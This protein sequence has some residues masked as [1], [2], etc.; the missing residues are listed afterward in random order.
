[1]PSV[2]PWEVLALAATALAAALALP[3]RALTYAVGGCCCQCAPP[4]T[5]CGATCV[6]TV[7]FAVISGSGC[8]GSCTL[9]WLAGVWLGSM[10]L[11]GGNCAGTLGVKLYCD[12]GSWKIDL[13]GCATGTGI[14]LTGTCAPFNIT[15][16]VF[17]FSGT[18]CYTGTPVNVTLTV[19]A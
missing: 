16:G 3:W 7:G 1:M 10:T 18:G 2:G 8:S 4:T 14:I 19:S 6:P 13:S 17:L 11:G 12:S 9:T 5:C 15:S